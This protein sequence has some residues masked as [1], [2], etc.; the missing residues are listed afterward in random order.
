[1]GR[2]RGRGLEV[3]GELDVEGVALAVEVDEEGVGVEEVGAVLEIVE[4]GDLAGG[5]GAG[6]EA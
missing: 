5:V 1:M 6:E 4:E 2:G 3:L